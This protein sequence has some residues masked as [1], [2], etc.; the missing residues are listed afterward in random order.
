VKHSTISG[1]RH[2][3]ITE[4]NVDLLFGLLREWLG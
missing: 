1:N 2:L 3:F 4:R